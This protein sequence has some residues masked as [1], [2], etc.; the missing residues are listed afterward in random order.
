VAEVK[1]NQILLPLDHRRGLVNLGGQ[2]LKMIYGTATISDVHEL[3]KA[4][5]NLREKKL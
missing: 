4:F 5:E 2:A 3:H 1:F